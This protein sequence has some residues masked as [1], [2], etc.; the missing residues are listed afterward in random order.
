MHNIICTQSSP[1]TGLHLSCIGCQ[2]FWLSVAGYKPFGWLYR[3]NRASS[4][5]HAL[6][7][8]EDEG[9]AGEAIDPRQGLE[10]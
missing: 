3:L 2:S 9:W 7:C 5:S 10:L 8:L 6:G 1:S 4:G